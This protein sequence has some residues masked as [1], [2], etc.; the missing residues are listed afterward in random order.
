MASFKPNYN[1]STFFKKESK[2]A[3]T[4]YKR[5]LTL[6]RGVDNDDAPRKKKNNRKSWL[7]NTG[8]TRLKGIERKNDKFSMTIFASGK[9]H[10][11]KTRWIARGKVR[12][13]KAKSRAK[14]TYNRP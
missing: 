7:I 10:S 13:G 3:V 14:G 2:T 4:Q 8:E 5:L 12:T 6:G 1:F 9:K 11:G